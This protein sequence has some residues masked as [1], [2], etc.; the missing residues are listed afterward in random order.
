MSDPAPRHM[1][2]PVIAMML[3]LFAVSSAPAYAGD[4]ASAML[5]RFH[6]DLVPRYAGVVHLSTADMATMNPDDVVL[7][8]V[9]KPSEYDVS[10]ID[11]AIRVSPSASAADFLDDHAGVIRGRTVVFYCSVGERSS[12]LA[13]G[14]M[15]R[16]AEAEAVYNL[17]GGIFK[18]HNEFRDVVAAN[19]DTTA[20]HPFNRRWGRLLERQDAI[21]TRPD[22]GS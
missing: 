13:Q 22:G 1:R 20:I 9:R 11:G 19:G 5:D 15:S 21:R 7:F 12:R 10:R 18:W 3:A 14:V 16:G 4:T 8:D 6:D 17:A 2:R